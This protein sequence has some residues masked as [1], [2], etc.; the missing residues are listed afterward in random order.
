MHADDVY[1]RGVSVKIDRDWGSGGLFS[2][3]A[4]K[5]LQKIKFF[6]ARAPNCRPRKL[7]VPAVEIIFPIRISQWPNYFFNQAFCL[8]HRD[9][10]TT[11]PILCSLLLSSS[12]VRN[13]R[14][15][16]QN[17]LCLG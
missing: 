12:A 1:G 3:K 16:S 9:V 15:W 8:G 11:Q 5:T 14:L 6:L 2:G 4:K 10:V 7:L 13:L 17:K